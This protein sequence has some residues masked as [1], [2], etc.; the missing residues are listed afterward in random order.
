MSRNFNNIEDLY[1][2]I[3]NRID[4][5]DSLSYSYQL[6]Q[7]GLEKINRKFGEEAIEVIIAA[8]N[9]QKDDSIKHKKELIGEIADIIYHL[10]VLMINQNLTFEDILKELNIRNDKK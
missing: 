9:K 6:D 10:T 3:K 7:E 8:F 4:S 5:K 1:I 2:K